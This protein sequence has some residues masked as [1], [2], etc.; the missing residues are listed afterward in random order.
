MFAWLGRIVGA[1]YGLKGFMGVLFMSIIG[2]IFY[3]LVVGLIGEALNFVVSEMNGTA[4][5]TV[6]SPSI[7]GFAGWALS[8][9]KIPECIGII[10]SFVAIKFV[11]RKIPLLRW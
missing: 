5:G 4:Y 9:L 8:E 10:T 7:S 6:T 1:V 3:N 2:I 11:L